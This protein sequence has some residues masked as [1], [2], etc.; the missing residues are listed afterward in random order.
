MNANLIPVFIQHFL[1]DVKQKVHSDLSVLAFS[2][3]LTN[4]VC[5]CSLKPDNSIQSL[6]IPNSSFK[7]FTIYNS[8]L[9]IVTYDNLQDDV[10]SM[11]EILENE[12]RLIK[13]TVTRQFKHGS[14]GT[15]ALLLSSRYLEGGELK[16]KFESIDL[17]KLLDYHM[18]SP[19]VK[20]TKSTEKNI[21]ST[22]Q[23]KDLFNHSRIASAITDMNGKILGV[24]KAFEDL[25]GYSSMRLQEGMNVD[26]LLIKQD[27]SNGGN[28]SHD[29]LIETDLDEFILL[30]K[31]NEE[32][33]VR[34][35]INDLPTANRRIVQL[36]DLTKTR[37]HE[38]AIREEFDV[39]LTVNRINEAI[40][41]NYAMENVLDSVIKSLAEITEFDFLTVV[42]STP[43]SSEF[44]L[45]TF[46]KGH[47]M[48]SNRLSD[49][50][51][52]GLKNFIVELG[53]GDRLIQTGKTLLERIRWSLEFDVQSSLVVT[54]NTADGICGA[55]GLYS[56]L[57]NA[58]SGYHFDVLKGVRGQIAFALMRAELHRQS[59]SALNFYQRLQA[60]EDEILEAQ[61]KDEIY[62]MTSKA[63]AMAV[64]AKFSLIQSIGSDTY[65]PEKQALSL[66]M[67]QK[68]KSVL[69]DGEPL[70][71]KNLYQFYTPE[72]LKQM[73]LR[74][75]S[76]F[77]ISLE[78]RK[79]ALLYLYFEK[80]H[81]L[82]EQDVFFIES[83]LEITANA[84][85]RLKR[86]QQIEQN[87]SEYK[88]YIDNSADMM[89][90]TDMDGNI[91]FLNES[92]RQRLGYSNGY[93]MGKT[94]NSLML[95]GNLQF[96]YLKS[97]LLNQK[98]HITFNGE[99]LCSAGQFVSVSWIFSAIR[100]KDNYLGFLGI[101]RDIT[102]SQ[103]FQKASEAKYEDLEQFLLKISHNLRSPLATQQGY[104]SLLKQEY[105]EKLDEEGL[106]YIERLLKNSQQMDAMISNLLYF[107]RYNRA[108]HHAEN[109][110]LNE[111]LK[112]IIDDVSY[113]RNVYF[114]LP[115]DLPSLFFDRDELKT[116]FSNLITNSIKYMG[117]VDKPRIAIEFIRENGDYH[118]QVTDNGIGIEKKHQPYIFDMF[119][120][121]RESKGVE[122]TGIGLAI[123]K[124]IIEN[125]HGTIYVN[126]E[127]GK[128]TSI[129]F[130]IPANN[131]LKEYVMN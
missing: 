44:N 59:M 69:E 100:E 120:R 26:D 51:H 67:N 32:R 64:D 96:S 16:K 101:G 4:R 73:E 98:L 61:T 1:L 30:R 93:F 78:S 50:S 79:E 103:V 85:K 72:Q 54:M 57:R 107:L 42:I 35:I 125:H 128:G 52:H 20:H 5:V 70:I 99:M 43:I 15:G 86:F 9:F 106:F 111:L 109:V 12:F 29:S 127:P 2:S 24:N 121:T 126:S 17:L 25:T 76:I 71:L 53:D 45:Y 21:D 97:E 13:T 115:T 22:R 91:M 119:Y 38:Q 83:I 108:E 47:E 75:L 102:E 62:R 112:T 118:F 89:I 65:L 122:G 31:N 37:Q 87:L 6:V 34:I 48:I 60:F 95:N 56:S 129:H 94:L 7:S 77:P 80:S 18:N 84:L 74:S 116:I 88:R 105:A 36:I 3:D 123:V 11:T 39:L 66:K 58:Y 117:D 68:I 113:N 8:N 131:V 90:V 81:A 92:G 110:D 55:I 41:S 49:D 23:T 40:N 33:F 10:T 63:A 130:T 46:F 114:S 124:K 19:E 27:V 28:K 82:I 104:L 14:L